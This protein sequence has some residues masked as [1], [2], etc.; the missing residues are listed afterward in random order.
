MKSGIFTHYLWFAQAPALLLQK[1]NN[2]TPAVK[3]ITNK[4]GIITKSLYT[5][6]EDN[7]LRKKELGE[8]TVDI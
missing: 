2:V 5:G 7:T 1:Y 6:Y 8:K 3:H 4:N